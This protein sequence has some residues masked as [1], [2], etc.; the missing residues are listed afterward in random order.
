MFMYILNVSLRRAN[1]S[2]TDAISLSSL[3]TSLLWIPAIH[4]LSS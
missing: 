1:E 3:F 4:L 2:A